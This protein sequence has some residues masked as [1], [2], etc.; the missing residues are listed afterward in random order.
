MKKFAVSQKYILEEKNYCWCVYRYDGK[1]FRDG[2][3]SY[4]FPYNEQGAIDAIACANSLEK[5]FE[6]ES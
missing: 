6:G 3:V 4:N 2:V 5:E 1:S